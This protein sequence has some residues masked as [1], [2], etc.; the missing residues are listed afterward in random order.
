MK[1]G[2][3][4]RVRTDTAAKRLIKSE[5]DRPIVQHVQ[6][7]RASDEKDVLTRLYRF[8]YPSSVGRGGGT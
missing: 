4:G 6:G 5:V 2:G 3:R 8:A 7:Q 1:T